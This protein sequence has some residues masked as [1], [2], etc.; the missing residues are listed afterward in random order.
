MNFFEVLL[1][2][3]LTP[4]I[5]YLTIK[6]GTFAILRGMESYREYKRK[7]RDE[8]GR[9]LPEDWFDGPN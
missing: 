4:I 6:L 9:K 7:N 5:G 8:G 3:L 1:L 2:F